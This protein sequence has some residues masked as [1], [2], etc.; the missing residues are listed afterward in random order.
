[1]DADNAV[2]A[3][4]TGSHTVGK[5]LD[6]L[7]MAVCRQASDRHYHV[8]VTDDALEVVAMSIWF[9]LQFDVD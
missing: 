8:L 5:R 6:Q 2:K 3:E 1:M 9:D 4:A 7:D